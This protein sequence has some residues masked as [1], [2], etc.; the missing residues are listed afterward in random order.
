MRT[1]SNFVDD[2]VHNKCSPQ[3][4]LHEK[5]YFAKIKK[6]QTNKTKCS[7]ENGMPKRRFHVIGGLVEVTNPGDV[8]FPCFANHIARMRQNHTDKREKEGRNFAMCR[9]KNVERAE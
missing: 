9:V 1:T 5:F 6:K 8:I 2:G 4:F 7:F 3:S